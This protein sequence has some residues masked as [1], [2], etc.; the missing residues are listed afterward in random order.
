MTKTQDELRDELLNDLAVEGGKLFGEDDIVFAGE[1]FILPEHTDLDE[2]ISF[3][4]TRRDDEETVNVFAKTFN[5]RPYDGARATA[6]AI[7]Q[8]SGFTLGKTTYT[9]FGR[10]PPELITIST[11][12]NGETEQVPWG[13]MQIPGLHNTTVHLGAAKDATLGEIFSVRIE[14]PRKYRFHIA[15]LWA[16]IQHYLDT[17][18]IYRG[19]AID[20]EMNFLDVWRID[21]ND[22]HYA[23]DVEL[24]L[25][26]EIW[27]RIRYADEFTRLGQSPKRAYLLEGPYGSGKSGAADL[28]AQEALKYGW[29]FLFCRPDDDIAK[30]LQ[31]GRMYTPCVVFREDVDSI[32]RAGSHNIEKTLDL[33][34]GIDNKGLRMIVIMTTNH[35]DEIHKG[36]I[37]PGRLHGIIHIGPMDSAA[38]QRLTRRVVGD[39]L[40]T[41][42]DWELVGQ[43]MEGYMPAFVREA[44]DRAVGYSVS[45]HGGKLGPIGTGDLVD[46]ANSL[47]TQYQMM[48]DADE[49]RPVDAVGAA[50]ETVVR[51]V[52]NATAVNDSDGDPWGTLSMANGHG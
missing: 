5:Y 25:R 14:A 24:R 40:A 6:K 43:S 47:R 28:T 52:I 16:R 50:V 44:L 8:G 11:G 33:M 37:R 15:G 49:T 21:R 18:S 38:V 35:A 32:A 22:F 42:I 41:D 27:D 51:G 13:A 48:E 23:A 31:M 4:E 17:D 46:A 36:M 2:A 30:V 9:M 7:T 26:C 39:K 29:T 12:P 3:L 19:K 34:D 10:R 45:S 1:K 20:G